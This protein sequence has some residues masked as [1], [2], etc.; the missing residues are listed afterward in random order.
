MTA[1]TSTPTWAQPGKP[2]L[3]K[4]EQY[5][6]TT[7]GFDALQRIY[8]WSEKGNFSEASEDDMKLCRWFGLYQQKPNA[9]GF[10]ML[11]V[12][13]PGGQASPLQL[14]TLAEISEKYGRGLADITTRQTIQ[15]HWLRIEHIKPIFQTLEK[16]GLFCQFACGDTPRNVVSCPLAGVSKDEII[17]A[18]SAV[19]EVN[20]MYRQAG[21]EFSNLP[22]KYKSSIGGCH[23]H[24][25]QPQINDVAFFGV[26][27]KSG[28]VGYGV[29]VGGGLSDTPHFAQPMRVFVKPAQI[30]E[31]ARAIAAVFRDHGYR[32]KRTRARLKFL[33]A[34]KGW[35]W[36][37][38]RIEEKLGYKL[39]HD[40]SITHPASVHTDHM[41]VGEQ[42]DGRFYVGAPVERGRWTS[43]QMRRVADIADA[44][45]VGEKR[46]R[47]TNKQN[48]VLL[49]IPKENVDKVVKALDDAGLP[50][51]AH[52][53]RDLLVSCTGTQFCN[54]AVVETKARSGAMLRWLEENTR[55]DVPV[56]IAVVG[57]PNSCAQYQIADIGLTGTMTLDPVRKDEK[58]KALKVEGYKILL[59]ARLGVDPKFGEVVGRNKVPGDRVHLSIKSL[60]D[61]YMEDRADSDEPFS[62]WVERTEPEALLKLIM[63]PAEDP[64]AVTLPA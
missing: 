48:A 30:V 61:R 37:R 8:A 12:K 34:D 22:R 55:I 26:R 19:V 49:D 53:L 11:R 29:L 56:M 2:P 32:E 45:A 43:Q 40:D 35:E 36:T 28:E 54:L 9:D 52:R 41:G 1:T 13:V 18:Q 4:F 6:L 47:L 27:R 62:Q 33:V 5:K 64:A 3:S 15:F 20:E 23:L 44:N 10:F 42:K 51:H 39:E 25:Q 21:R 60:L 17:D 24:C 46:I 31:V 57:C 59:G 38:D 16:V 50:P 58:G 14:R 7:D 63:T